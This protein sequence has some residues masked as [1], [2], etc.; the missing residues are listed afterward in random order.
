MHV[1]QRVETQEAGA[2]EISMLPSKGG[3]PRP[4]LT[5]CSSGQKQMGS[6]TYHW[7]TVQMLARAQQSEQE[8]GLPGRVENDHSPGVCQGGAPLGLRT[9]LAP[10]KMISQ[11]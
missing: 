3:A 6:A 11:Q 4:L 7:N 1:L 2:L 10:Q 9:G 8:V 5:L